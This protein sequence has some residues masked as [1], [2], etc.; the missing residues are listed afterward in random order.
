MKKNIILF[1]VV[2]AFISGYQVNAQRADGTKILENG[3][4]VSKDW[5]PKYVGKIERKSLPVPYLDSPQKTIPINIGRQLFIDSYLIESTSLKPVQHTPVFSKSNPVL[6]A[7]KVWE[8]N[9]SGPFAAP[10]SDG[11]WFDES[12]NKFKMWYLAG[13]QNSNSYY[14]CYAESYN[15]IS[16]V[17]P[18]LGV[19]GHTNI[20]DI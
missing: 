3:L 1:L 6:F 5:P 20:V 18:D 2:A 4:E 8:Y 14:T 10:F 15:G 13:K 7:D 9:S 16:W 11:I 19:Y 12:D 17:K